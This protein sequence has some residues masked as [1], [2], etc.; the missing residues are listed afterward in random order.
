MGVCG[1]QDTVNVEL[2]ELFLV[3]AHGGGK[4]GRNNRR[5]E[6]SHRLCRFSAASNEELVVNVSG[7][8][9]V[10]SETGI[11]PEICSFG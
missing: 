4:G 5:L 8:Q 1:H 11:A 9:G 7:A 3:G 2:K 6:V 10:K